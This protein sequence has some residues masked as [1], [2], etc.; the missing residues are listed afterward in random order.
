[1]WRSTTLECSL[2]AVH[3]MVELR[4]GAKGEGMAK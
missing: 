1:M 3:L 2:I 4:E